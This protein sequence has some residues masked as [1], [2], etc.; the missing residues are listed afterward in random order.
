MPERRVILVHGVGQAPVEGTRQACILNLS[1]LGL[2]ADE[3]HEYHWNSLS[4]Q[5][6][7]ASQFNVPID[8]VSSLIRGIYGSAVIGQLGGSQAA[9]RTAILALAAP[10]PL[11]ALWGAAVFLSRAVQAGPQ[12]STWYWFGLESVLCTPLEVMFGSLL[13]HSARL[14]HLVWK[15]WIVSAACLAGLYL[16]GSALRKR[17]FFPAIRTIALAFTWPAAGAPML[18]FS[19]LWQFTIFQVVCFALLRVSTPNRE[20]MGRRTAESGGLMPMI[21]VVAVG[22]AAYFLLRWILRNTFAPTWKV[23]ADILRY[24]GDQDYQ[25]RI[26]AGLKHRLAHLGSYDDT[27][28]CLAGHSLGSVI[29]VH[30]LADPNSPLRAARSVTLVTLGSPLRRFF[31][32]F[33]PSELPS[34]REIAQSLSRQYRD[35]HWINVYRPM[36]PIG[37]KIFRGRSSAAASEHST[38]QWGRLGIRAHTNYWSDPVVAHWI[39]EGL[40]NREPGSHE[41]P[42]RAAPLLLF[43]GTQANM[44]PA[45]MARLWNQWVVWAPAVLIAGNYLFGGAYLQVSDYRETRRF[46][47]QDQRCVAASV[48]R[49]E[50]PVPSVSGAPTVPATWYHVSFRTEGSIGSQ[51]FYVP[52]EIAEIFEARRDLKVCYRSDQPAKFYVPGYEPAWP[53]DGW[54]IMNSALITGALTGMWLWL[55]R[56]KFALKELVDGYFG[57]PEGY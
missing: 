31:F 39:R 9:I 6:L 52:D 40:A 49:E 1:D 33:F 28:V 47:E 45:G 22:I 55:A 18:V 3:V 8:F 12:G 36:D 17:S 44:R 2:K 46:V 57:L 38:K 24:V 41:E 29:A 4:D 37:T 34:P 20:I 42:G 19:R 35:F 27:D 11:L 25:S 10:A 53:P 23:L 15:L 16:G 51:E 5:P 26:Q 7:D 21:L 14:F 43:P 56:R 30:A 48:D 32:R 13:E 50:I 54:A